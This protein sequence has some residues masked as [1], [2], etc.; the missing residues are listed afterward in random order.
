MIYKKPLLNEGVVDLVFAYQLVK[1]LAIPFNKWEAYKLGII[2]E[3]GVLL[4]TPT[5]DE[6]NKSWGYFDIIVWNIKKII[7]KFTGNSQL[8]AALVTMYLAKEGSPKN[9]NEAV[10]TN[11]FDKKL[12]NSSNITLA[13][14]TANYK[15]LKG[16][17][18]EH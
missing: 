2:D 14:T 12:L 7:T 5:D 4:R 10:L 3:K 16:Y 18:Y 9:V 1:R 15:T 6:R 17:L 8:S 13:E 11:L